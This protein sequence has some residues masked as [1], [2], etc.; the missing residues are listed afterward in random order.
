LAPWTATAAPPTRTCA[1]VS[2][3]VSLPPNAE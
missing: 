3:G 2:T 1:M